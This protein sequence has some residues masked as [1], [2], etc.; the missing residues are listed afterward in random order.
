MGIEEHLQLAKI[1]KDA[2]N[3]KGYS[4]S[5]LARSAGLQ[6][7][8]VTRLEAAQLHHPQPETL[9]SIARVL[10]LPVADLFVCLN[11][12]PKDQLPRFTPYLH[13]KYGDLPQW[14]QERLGMEFTKVA[15]RYGYEPN[16]SRPSPDEF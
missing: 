5:A 2:R 1:I 3:E 7:S 8:T 12:M 6:P 10:D 9:V 14:V 13:A 11:W 16:Q 15:K 4:A